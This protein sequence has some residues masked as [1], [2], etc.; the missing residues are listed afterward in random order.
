MVLEEQ[1]WVNLPLHSIQVDCF[2]GIDDDESAFIVSL[3]HCRSANLVDTNAKRGGFPHWRHAGN[4]FFLKL[5]YA[6]GE[7][8]DVS[9]MMGVTEAKNQPHNKVSLESEDVHHW[10]GTNSVL[11]DF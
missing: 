7:G 4:Q 9:P 1:A 11:L 6:S 5:N 10:N 2:A 3:F 8:N